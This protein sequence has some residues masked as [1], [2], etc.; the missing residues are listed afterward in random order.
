MDLDS[1]LYILGRIAYKD[2]DL[3]KTVLYSYNLW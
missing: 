2:I 1:W 3:W